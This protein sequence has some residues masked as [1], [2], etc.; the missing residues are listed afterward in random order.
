M[1]IFTNL[2]LKKSAQR[3][4]GLKHLIQPWL[5]DGPELPHLQGMIENIKVN[6]TTEVYTWTTIHKI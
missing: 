4:T 1:K 2:K 6:Y 5:L 3:P